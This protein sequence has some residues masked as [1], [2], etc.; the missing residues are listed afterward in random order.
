MS[1]QQVEQGLG[2]SIINMIADKL[3]LGGSVIAPALGY[4][5]PKLIG[6]LT[7]DG[8]VPYTIPATWKSFLDTSTV[9]SR[10]GYREP[11]RKAGVPNWLLGLIPLLALLGI[12]W[13]LLSGKEEPVATQP[14]VQVA[15][16]TPIAP[17]VNPRLGV[18]YHDSGY[19]TYSGVVKDEATRASIIDAIKGVFGAGN[20]KGDIT[21][22][23]NAGVAPWLAN[24][25]AAL[26]SQ[27]PR[28]AGGL[29]RPSVGQPLATEMEIS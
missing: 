16:T 4:V 14:P 11:A 2:T 1:T 3:G 13:W 8:T 26:D 19:V 29:L 21:L 7:P 15:Q 23:P 10:P 27:D 12:A 5:I 28:A 25:K 20:A 24:L 9:Q 18:N 17:T 22:D 6:M